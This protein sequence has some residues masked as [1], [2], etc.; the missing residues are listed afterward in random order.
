MRSSRV[1]LVPCFLVGLS[2]LF[3][4]VPSEG[5]MLDVSVQF[6]CRWDWSFNLL[7]SMPYYQQNWREATKDGVFGWCQP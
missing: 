4:I 7:E 5:F 2:A 3:G 1:H 6:I